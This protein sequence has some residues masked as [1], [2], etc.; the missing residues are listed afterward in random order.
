MGWKYWK[1]NTSL[2]VYFSV[3]YSHY[4]LK[5]IHWRLVFTIYGNSNPVRCLATTKDGLLVSSDSNK[6]LIL[7]PNNGRCSNYI[8]LCC[9]I[10]SIV[11][12][13]NGLIATSCDTDC[14]TI[15]ILDNKLRLIDQLKRH[16]RRV[17]QLVVLNNGCLASCSDDETIKIWD[18]T[19]KGIF[20][21]TKRI[22]C[23]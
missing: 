18:T 6:L 12:L 14:G 22:L 9:E 20:S 16:T 7:N 19:G 4:V 2:L 23:F 21:K 3:L 11:I 5:F 10:H 8:N 1:V 15:N 13:N 17:N